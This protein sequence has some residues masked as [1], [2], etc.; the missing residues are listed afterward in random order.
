MTTVEVARDGVALLY[1]A[2]ILLVLS[3]IVF[4]MRVGV[5]MWRKAWGMDDY[6][7]FVGTV[8][9]QHHQYG[10]RKLI[11][12]DRLYSQSQPL[13][14]SSVVTMAPDSFPETCQLQQYPKEQKYIYPFHESLL[15]PIL[16]VPSSFISRSTSM[17]S[18]PCSSRSVLP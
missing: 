15:E 12:C 13:F 16:T 3:W 18:A 5:R 6:L 7:M 17:L 14:A 1:C 11:A 2:V 8:R 9:V 4:C 10:I